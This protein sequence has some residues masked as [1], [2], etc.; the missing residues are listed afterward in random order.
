MMVN[1][2]PAASSY[3]VAIPRTYR[4]ESYRESTFGRSRGGSSVRFVVDPVGSTNFRSITGS[5]INTP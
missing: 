4:D 1:E 5:R 3:F 2:E